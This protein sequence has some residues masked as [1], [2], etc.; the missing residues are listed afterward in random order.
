MKGPGMCTM[1]GNTG[2]PKASGPGPLHWKL[3]QVTL[4]SWH[5]SSHLW[6]ATLGSLPACS[7]LCLDEVL[8]KQ[9]LSQGFLGT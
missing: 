8:E 4:N 1:S 5:Q 2:P 9:S 6:W 3:L 7:S